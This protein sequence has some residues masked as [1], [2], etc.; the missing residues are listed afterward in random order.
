M[1]EILQPISKCILDSQHLWVRKNIVKH[2]E[3]TCNAC[4]IIQALD[5]TYE[6]LTPYCLSHYKTVGFC[7]K[8]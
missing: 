3:E 4:E 1:S 6:A 7:F 5:N 2:D 8:S